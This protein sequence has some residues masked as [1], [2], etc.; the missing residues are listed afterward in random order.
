MGSNDKD[1]DHWD[2]LREIDEHGQGLTDW[3]VNF[4]DDLLKRRRVVESLG[5][6]TAGQVKKIEQI[7]TDRV[8]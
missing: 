3:E 2:T 4:V 1:W 5:G 6:L 7:Y 8:P